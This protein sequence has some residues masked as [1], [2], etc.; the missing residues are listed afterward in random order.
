MARLYD[1]EGDDEEGGDEDA[2]N[3]DD[4]ERDDADYGDVEGSPRPALRG[5][6]GA[7]GSAS[8]NGR[9]GAHVELPKGPT[10]YELWRSAHEV[11]RTA[12]DV[13]SLIGCCGEDT[14]T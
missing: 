7:D 1:E 11:D 13:S 12:K 2:D 9:G 8:L 14:E 6:S 3:F 5:G 4:E 10:P